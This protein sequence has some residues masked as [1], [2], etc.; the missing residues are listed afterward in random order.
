LSTEETSGTAYTSR[1]VPDPTVLT[2]EQLLREIAGVDQKI[3]A[4]KELTE[5][6]LEGLEAVVA[7]KFI[8]VDTQFGLIERQR[9]EQKTDTGNAL[10]AALAAAKEAVTKT[11]EATKEQIA[12]LKQTFDTALAGMQALLND[13]RDRV[14]RIENVKQGGQEQKSETRESQ[15]SLYAFLG[16]AVVIA[17]VVG[18]Y[19]H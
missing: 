3:S 4:L 5:S 7:E 15:A 9:V 6:D 14:A 2:T 16:L 19:I 17:G 18:H 1:P 12:Q 10:A 13:V 8:T 11:E